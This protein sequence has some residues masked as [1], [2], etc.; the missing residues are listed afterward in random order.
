MPRLATAMQLR[1]RMSWLLGRP[2][3]LSLFNLAASGAR[4][5]MHHAR[6]APL[7]PIVK[8]DISPLCA[9]ACPACLHADPAGRNRP[10]LDRQSFKPSDR[11]ELAQFQ[12]IISQI[13]GR[14]LAVSLYYYGD[15]L[16]HRQFAEFVRTAADAG[17]ATHAST[18]LSYN[19]SDDRIGAILASG[20]T[21]L[22][23]DVD[24]ATQESYG[25]TRVRGRLDLVLDNLRRLLEERDRRG[26]SAP[27]I[28]VQH[29]SFAHHPPGEAGRVEALVRALGVD[30]FSTFSGAYHDVHG[31]LYNAVDT[32]V[33]AE[34]PG[35]PRSR[36]L[37]PRCHWPYSGAVIK[38]DG[39]V[40]PCCKWREGQ[41]YSEGGEPRALGNV[42][43]TPLE[44]IWNGPAYR[45][46][47]R[48]VSNPARVTSAGPTHSFCEGCPKLYATPAPLGDWQPD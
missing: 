16:M 45:A 6:A 20:L 38:Y 11:M 27:L 29:L 39:D 23:V 43:N 48:E 8:I 14:T 1:R 30:A 15:P 33:G 37:L 47:R 41:Q 12:K 31:D 46:V 5:A 35:A 17:L 28:E 18:H 9:L 7:P 36:S 44:D 3:V 24:G 32:D 22:T 21:H 34:E 2:S 25:A 13:K 42:F 26:L 19:L 10:L 40:I 4:Y